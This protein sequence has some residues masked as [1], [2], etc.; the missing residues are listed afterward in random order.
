MWIETDKSS[1]DI[2]ATGNGACMVV[3]GSVKY[4]KSKQWRNASTAI[5]EGTAV[6]GGG[7]G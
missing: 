3:C 6:T 7:G 4:I 1:N 5:E 2:T